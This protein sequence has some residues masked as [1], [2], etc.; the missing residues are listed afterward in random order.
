M[1]Y[2]QTEKA[3]RKIMPDNRYQG[4][5]GGPQ[6]GAKPYKKIDGFYENG[7]IKPHLFDKKAEEMAESFKGVTGTQLRRLFDEV[8][9]FEKIL[10]AFPEQWD[11][12]EPYIRMIKSKSSYTVAR[13]AAK[14]PK[15]DTQTKGAYDNLR[16]F[17]AEGIDTVKEAKDYQ[18][19]A[20]LFEAVYGY[21][22]EK[23]PRD[24]AS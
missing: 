17:I 20:S 19:F 3:R 22:Y 23:A 14:L 2:T 1:P 11:K 5:R 24:A 4:N 15:Y 7:K 13:A 10:D 8:K 16:A 18:I 12:Q 21:Y 9:R 6:E